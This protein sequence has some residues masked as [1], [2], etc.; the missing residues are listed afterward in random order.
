MR[1]LLLV[2]AMLVS[3]SALAVECLGPTDIQKAIDTYHQNEMR[4]R[5]D[6]K[7]KQIAFTWNFSSASAYTHSTSVTFGGSGTSV[8]CRDVS[9]QV[10]DLMV[11]WDKGQWASVE[12]TID[13][14]GFGDTLW[15]KNCRVTA[16]QKS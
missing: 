3:T 8:V 6:F 16:A 15:L 14:A 7:G 5:R 4:F 1:K 10:V 2:S 13:D 9:Q 12:G 11:D